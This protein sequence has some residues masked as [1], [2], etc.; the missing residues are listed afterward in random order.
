MIASDCA[1][2]GYTLIYEC[3]V[4]GVFVGTTVW[5]GT[6]LNCEV[7]TVINLLHSEF[8]SEGGAIGNCN[9]GAIIGQSLRIENNRYVSQLRVIVSNDMSG[10]TIECVYDNGATTTTIGNY[11]INLTSTRNQIH[12]FLD[13]SIM[14]D[15][16]F[17]LLLQYL[18]SHPRT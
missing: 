5:Q 7:G 16:Y 17:A 1:C 15:S 4:V 12:T 2:P 11:S 18:S 13:Q 3:S 6:A 8:I 9:G 14:Y 10:E